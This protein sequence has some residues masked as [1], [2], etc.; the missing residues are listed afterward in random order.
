MIQQNL[1]LEELPND[2][3][4]LVS[5]LLH[6]RCSDFQNLSLILR[7]EVGW[8]VCLKGCNSCFQ[9]FK[10]WHFQTLY[11]SSLLAKFALASLSCFCFFKKSRER[12]A[13]S[14]IVFSSR[15]ARWELLGGWRSSCLSWA[16]AVAAF[17][18]A[19]LAL[20]SSAVFARG[21][22]LQLFLSNLQL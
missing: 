4:E 15:T 22:L 19:S 13:S 2:R 6:S 14:N 18:S 20:A 12:F 11:V 3:S 17:N 10:V 16:F 9:S 21:R 1:F 8:V 7:N 5:F